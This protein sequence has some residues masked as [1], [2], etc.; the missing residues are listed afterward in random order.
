MDAIHHS[1][2]TASSRV[3]LIGGT[4][5]IGRSIATKLVQSGHFAIAAARHTPTD[6]PTQIEKISCAVSDV[7]RLIALISRK[8][9]DTVVHLASSLLP[10]SGEAMFLKERN[11]ITNPTI[12]LASRL[13][14][15]AVR[16]VYISSGGT[17]YGVSDKSFV[18][19]T[20]PTAPI[21][22]YGQSKL[23]TESHLRFLERTK[24]LRL[25]ILRPS[26]PYGPGQSF[27]GTQGLVSV[28][29]GRMKSGEPLQVWGDGSSTRDYIYI[30]D[31]INI[32]T[33]L[34]KANAEGITLNIGSGVGASLMDVVSVIEKVTNRKIQ[35]EFRPARPMD[36]PTLILDVTRL[37][38]MGLYHARSLSD[39]VRCYIEAIGY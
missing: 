39:G 33:Q 9:I 30:D 2:K 6:W 1:A 15:C 12:Q 16:L 37:K 8:K 27:T 13:A 4:G 34:I 23:E 25:L 32:I 10:S 38:E 11:L 24:S 36:V 26:N 35:L 31:L 17:I 3:L 5:F 18:S 28:I 22:F 21:S 20:S 29:L 7:D 19:E 14:D